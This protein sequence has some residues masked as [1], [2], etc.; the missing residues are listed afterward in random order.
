MRP[1]VGI[2]S[3]LEDVSCKFKMIWILKVMTGTKKHNL[4]SSILTHTESLH[5]VGPVQPL[6]PQ[7][8]YGKP[9]VGAALA[10]VVVVGVV[11]VL[12]GSARQ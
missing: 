4:H 6:P 1:E 8:S 9:I 12:A 10:E 11:R 7:R 3:T 2:A 5:V